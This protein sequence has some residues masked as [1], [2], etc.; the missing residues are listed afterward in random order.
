[1]YIGMPE[2]GLERLQQDANGSR[3]RAALE[4]QP[5]RDAKVDLP[6]GGKEPGVRVRITGA[7]QLGEPPVENLSLGQFAPLLLGGCHCHT[8]RRLDALDA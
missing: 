2:G 4:E 5:L 7:G 3:R 8:V 6:V 1:M